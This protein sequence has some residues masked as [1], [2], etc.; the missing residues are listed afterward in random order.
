MNNYESMEHLQRSIKHI[1][2]QFTFVK[3]DHTNG[4]HPKLHVIYVNRSI[5]E[6]HYTSIIHL[7]Y[8][9]KTPSYREDFLGL[10]RHDKWKQFKSMD[11]ISMLVEQKRNELSDM[12]YELN[13]LKVMMDTL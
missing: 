3:T 4:Y 6:L 12:R 7:L 10:I 13:R 2:N 11:F 1:P 8:Q 5:N 9:K